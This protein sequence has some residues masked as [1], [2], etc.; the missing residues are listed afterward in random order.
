M[1]LRVW[2]MYHQ[3][4]LILG[5]LLVFYTISLISYLI[6]RILSTKDIGM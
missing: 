6:N 3:S 1:I 5:T 2:V 4:R